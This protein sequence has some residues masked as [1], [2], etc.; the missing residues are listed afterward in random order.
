MTKRAAKR[1]TR[2]DEGED[3]MQLI[4]IGKTEAPKT[5]TVREMFLQLAE[6]EERMIRE[7]R[8]RLTKKI[9]T[10]A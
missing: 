8:E 9:P 2:A 4:Q 6:K 5:V 7:G 10:T 1:R 3:D